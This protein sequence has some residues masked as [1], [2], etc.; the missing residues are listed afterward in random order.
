MVFAVAYVWPDAL[1]ALVALPCIRRGPDDALAGT[2]FHLVPPVMSEEMGM[3]EFL[4]LPS[5]GQQGSYHAASFVAFCRASLLGRRWR[6][7]R[8]TSGQARGVPC[9]AICNNGASASTASLIILRPVPVLAGRP[10][11]NQLCHDG[12]QR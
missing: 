12:P 8:R 7:R 11:R 10:Q 3:E 1:A 2:E 5:K 9:R 4:H 6:R